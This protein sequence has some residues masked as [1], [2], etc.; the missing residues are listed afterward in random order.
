MVR[1]NSTDE[2]CAVI[3]RLS[4]QDHDMMTVWL[5]S[6]VFLVL[7]MPACVVGSLVRSISCDMSSLSF[8]LYLAAVCC[9]CIAMS[10]FRLNWYVDAFC[11][12]C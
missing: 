10:N 5:C 11:L 9:R 8:K 12:S 3:F 1:V 2:T 7:E 6:C 4:M